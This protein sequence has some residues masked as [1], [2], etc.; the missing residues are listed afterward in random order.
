[1]TRRNFL[2]AYLDS[3]THTLAHA[4]ASAA[5]CAAIGH[6][7][8]ALATFFALLPD[9]DTIIP[10]PHRTL[11][12]SLLLAPLLFTSV[13]LLTLDVGLAIL[14]TAAWAS[15]LFVDLLHGQ[16]VYLLWPLRHTFTIANIPPVY[17]AFAAAILLILVWPP[18][19]FATPKPTATSTPRPVIVTR[20]PPFLVYP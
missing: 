9:I 2:P 6:P 3:F 10:I 13:Y 8:I 4:L 11:T 17:L 1:M 14:A 19:T 7:N 15:H 12:H 16:G 5:V 20:R 18:S